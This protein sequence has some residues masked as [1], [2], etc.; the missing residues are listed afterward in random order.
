MHIA[1]R[2]VLFTCVVILAAVVLRAPGL[3]GP[4]LWFDEAWS[5]FAAGQSTPWA[6]ANADATHQTRY[7]AQLQVHAGALGQ[8]ELE[9][10]LV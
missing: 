3:S 1:R 4:G 10:R 9:L 5:A 6:E 2:R 8:S 7:Y